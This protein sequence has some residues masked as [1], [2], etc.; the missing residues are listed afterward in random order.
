HRGVAPFVI[1]DRTPRDE[2]VP[3]ER[4]HPNGVTGVGAVVVAVDDVARVRGWYAAVL[5]QPGQDV[6]RPELD[7]A[8]AR[9]DIGPHAFEF[10]APAGPGGPLAAWLRTRG[11]SP[12]AATLRTRGGAAGPLDETKTFG[13]R[14]A[15]GA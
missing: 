14:L 11:A 7:A 13:A 4:G 15:L 5:G 1:T 10:L 8:G 2:R 3:R 9:F 12:Y 6:R